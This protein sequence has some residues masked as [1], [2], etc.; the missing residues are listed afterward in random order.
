MVGK[1]GDHSVKVPQVILN[2][3]IVKVLNRA[4]VQNLVKWEGLTEADASWE[5]TEE[6]VQKF[7]HFPMI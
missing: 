3:R 7:P 4:Q 6:F 2:K 1:M 5:N